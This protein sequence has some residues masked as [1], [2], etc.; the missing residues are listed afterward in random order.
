MKEL[1]LKIVLTICTLFM[2]HILLAQ[3]NTQETLDSLKVNTAIGESKL[4]SLAKIV[5]LNIFSNDLLLSLDRLE[6]E[7]KK[8]NDNYYLLYSYNYRITYYIRNYNQDSIN[9]YIKLSDPIAK[10]MNPSNYEVSRYEFL[11]VVNYTARG[12]FDLALLNQ[13]KYLE[14][15]K[16]IE[17]VQ[18]EILSSIYIGIGEAY[19]QQEK[20]KEA[21]KYFNQAL[22]II[23]IN[24]TLRHVS[25]LCLIALCQVDLN[26][27]AEAIQSYD[28]ANRIIKQDQKQITDTSSAHL[29]AYLELIAIQAYTGLKEFEKAKPLVNNVIENL[30]SLLYQD[31]EAYCYQSIYTYYS[32]IK[33]YDQALKYA[34]L[35]LIH[36]KKHNNIIYQ[37]NFIKEKANLFCYIGNYKKAYDELLFAT[38]MADSIRSSHYA[39][40]LD[41]L[42]TMY[43]VDLKDAEIARAKTH[44]QLTQTIIIALVIASILLS[45]IVLISKANN[46]K[47]KMKNKVLFKQQEELSQNIDHYKKMIVN[48]VD[49]GNSSATV[50]SIFKQL[51]K[52]MFENE[53]YKD[54]NI[55]RE[56]LA[57]SL[58]TNRQY[59]SSAIKDETGLTFT[60]YI[61]KYRLDNARKLLLEDDKAAIDDIIIESGFSSRSTFHRLFK[62][63]YGMAPHE[64]KLAAISLRNELIEEEKVN[65]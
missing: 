27:Y 65:L 33:E 1:I 62:E 9:R 19:Y 52:Y 64:F 56:E 30:D 39:I 38:R 37:P 49:R 48:E 36:L 7:A 8:Q 4:K 42:A 55:N 59:L 61:N 26:D 14:K 25:I 35:G 5:E 41:E 12:L 6:K 13:K 20:Y 57:I 22:D 34:E 63:R 24:N 17:N 21:L 58:N 2:P 31:Q 16:K 32:A 23:K 53:A 54:P 50:N 43:E 11:K 29:K 28:L 46:R 40:Q 47:Q 45:I 44:L 51:E 3:E 60:N 15:I 10:Q 18:P